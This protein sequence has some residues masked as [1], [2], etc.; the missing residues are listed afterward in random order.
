MGVLIVED[1][2]GV[3]D[4][5]VGVLREEGYEVAAV[6]DGAAALRLLE[7]G[8]LPS[9][10]LLD[11]MMP[12]MDGVEFRARQLAHPRWAQIPVIVLSAHSDVEQRAKQ[13]A[14]DDFLPKP[15]SCE[16]LLHAVQNR[17][18]TSVSATAARQA[19]AL[20][21]QEAWRRLRTRSP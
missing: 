9:L 2:A 6:A 3:R 7:A 8:P 11:L 5:L 14:A 17:A 13:L 4:A 21:L 15:M 10:I 16:A 12:N 18:V 19:R 1:D 20:T